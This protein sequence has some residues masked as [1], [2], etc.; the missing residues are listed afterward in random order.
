MATVLVNP[1]EATKQICH[2][3]KMPKWYLAVDR[4]QSEL[5]RQL[6]FGLIIAG[7]QSPLRLH[8]DP[9]LD[10]V[11]PRTQEIGP[12]KIPMALLNTPRILDIIYNA[13]DLELHQHP[14]AEGCFNGPSIDL[15]NYFAK[16]Q[17]ILDR[18][19]TLAI[20]LTLTCYTGF[21]TELLDPVRL[22][23]LFAGEAMQRIKDAAA[24]PAI[25]PPASRRSLFP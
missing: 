24:V 18:L 10:K 5:G 1:T 2:E 9:P 4:D 7:S 20:G 6:S 22:E 16:Q 8:T 14:L 17:T 13:I 25:P 23:K 19:P 21:K 15:A 3:L 11:L 12:V